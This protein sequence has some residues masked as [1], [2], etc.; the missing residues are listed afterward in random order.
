M[1]AEHDLDPAA[2]T[3]EERRAKRRYQAGFAFETMPEK[4][5]EMICSFRWMA[6]RIEVETVPVEHLCGEPFGHGGV[7][8]C[9]C[10]A[11]VRRH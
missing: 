8:V 11:Y 2:M 9:C 5:P 7:C 3:E 1:P 10:G 4:L 6:S